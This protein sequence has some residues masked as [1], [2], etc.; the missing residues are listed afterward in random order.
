MSY[1]VTKH[2]WTGRRRAGYKV[3]AGIHLFGSS[4]ALLT[5]VTSGEC[6]A[7]GNLPS[8]LSLVL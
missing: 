1:N 2:C 4:R 5:L 6:A 7:P 8:V 3:G